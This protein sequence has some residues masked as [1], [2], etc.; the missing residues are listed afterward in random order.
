MAS[1]SL[2]W[3]ES[4][5]GPTTGAAVQE[6]HPVPPKPVAVKPA[7]KLSVTVTVPLV[8]ALPRL[9]TVSV[10][11]WP[12]SPWVKLPL[13]L[14]WMVRSGPLMLAGSVAVSLV[15]FVSPPPATLAV[16]LTVPPKPHPTLTVSVID[17]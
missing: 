10:Y 9:L 4:A 2:R 7:G 6:L 14:F 12:T 11:C 8:G 16:L 15:V 5:P 13:W 17:G 1:A 3:Q